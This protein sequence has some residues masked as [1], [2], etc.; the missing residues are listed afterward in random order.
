MACIVRISEAVTVRTSVRRRKE[1]CWNCLVFKSRNIKC[2]S[3]LA[4]Y[5]DHGTARV[6]DLIARL[7]FAIEPDSAIPFRRYI[8]HFELN[9]AAHFLEGRI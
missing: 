7:T 1:Q 5:A 9:R 6:P 3:A 8:K 2:T 4:V